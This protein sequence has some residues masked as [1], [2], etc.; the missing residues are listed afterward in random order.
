[1]LDNDNFSCLLAIEEKHNSYLPINL[2]D[3]DIN[4]YPE[5]LSL[6]YIDT[7]TTTYN[8]EDIKESIKK[9]NVVPTESLDKDLVIIAPGIKR[10]FKIITKDMLENYDFT[11][12]IYQN[13]NNKDFVNRIIN[14]LRNLGLND[15]LIY[16]LKLGEIDKF[17]TNFNELPYVIQRNLYL[18]II[19]S[20]DKENKNI[21]IR[22]R[23]TKDKVAI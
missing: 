19:S 12:I 23:N 4:D 8:I 18:Y 1:M 9:A 15:D 6:A 5:V 10:K 11:K 21:R 16:Y 14:K 7:L 20:L 22:N 17:L 13:I 3:I 2:K